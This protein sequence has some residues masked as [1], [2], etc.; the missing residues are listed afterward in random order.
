MRTEPPP[1]TMDAWR[2]SVLPNPKFNREIKER[3]ILNLPLAF[4]RPEDP[5]LGATMF[6]AL[7]VDGTAVIDEG[8]LHGRSDVEKGIKW[9][10]TPDEIPEAVHY[11][12]AWIA[13]KGA[14]PDARYSGVTVSDFYVDRP[15][16]LGA[17]DLPGQV[18]AMSRA[19][20]GKVEL[21]GL[22]DGERKALG[23]LLRERGEASWRNAAQSFRQAF[24]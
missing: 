17:K 18:N 14:G 10:A 20:Q 11:W 1:D 15:R 19:L 6:A 24:D 23:R 16:R 22:P 21:E 3:A 9:K 7:L 5:L 12:V 8:L 2:R 4:M 13:V